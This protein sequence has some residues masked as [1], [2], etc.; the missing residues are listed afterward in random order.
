M[1]DKSTLGGDLLAYRNIEMAGRGYNVYKASP[2]API[3]EGF[4]DQLVEYNW[5]ITQ[6]DSNGMVYPSDDMELH[7]LISC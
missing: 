2:N 3:D 6:K 1:N 4:S 5:A 7:Q